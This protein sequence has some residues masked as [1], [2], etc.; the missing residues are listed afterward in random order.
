V[1]ASLTAAA[2]NE[3]GF[4]RAQCFCSSTRRAR[5][6]FLVLGCAFSQLTGVVAVLRR[7]GQVITIVAGTLLLVFGALLVAGRLSW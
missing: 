5:F 6:P 1:L 3:H 4:G 2:S 7:S